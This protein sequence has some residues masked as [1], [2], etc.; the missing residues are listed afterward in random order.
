M[1]RQKSKLRNGVRTLL[2]LLAIDSEIDLLA[3]IL[4]ASN[5]LKTLTIRIAH[6]NQSLEV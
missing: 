1:E 6:A 4:H 2:D 5:S 3:E